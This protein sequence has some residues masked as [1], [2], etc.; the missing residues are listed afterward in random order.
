MARRIPRTKELEEHR[1]LSADLKR[2]MED[3]RTKGKKDNR[4]EGWSV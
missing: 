4:T 3:D 1:H 2:K